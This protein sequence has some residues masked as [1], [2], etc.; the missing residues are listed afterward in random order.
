M[1]QNRN[2]IEWKV[3]TKAC[4][5]AFSLYNGKLTREASRRLCFDIIYCIFLVLY[6]LIRGFSLLHAVI[7]GNEKIILQSVVSVENGAD[8]YNNTSKR[9]RR[10]WF[11]KKNVHFICLFLS[12]LISK[13]KWLT[14]VCIILFVV[15][16]QSREFTNQRDGRKWQDYLKKT[17]YSVVNGNVVDHPPFFLTSLG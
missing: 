5:A 12:V 8:K 4:C 17:D 3:C 2:W 11:R 6:I 16:L 14:A 7:H 13:K 9:K 15:M 10:I 1:A